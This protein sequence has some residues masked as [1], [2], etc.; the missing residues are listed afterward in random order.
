MNSRSSFMAV[1]KDGDCT[2]SPVPWLDWMMSVTR[3]LMR[4]E[5][6][7]PSTWEMDTGMSMG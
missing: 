2:T 1:R 3:A 4:S 6:V 5:W 7:K